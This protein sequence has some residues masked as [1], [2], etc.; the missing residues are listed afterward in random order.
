MN[1]HVTL[2]GIVSIAALYGCGASC[3]N[4]CG[5]GYSDGERAGVVTKFS[6][7][8]L[9]IKSWEGEMALGGITTDVEGNAVANV[10]RFSVRDESLIEKLRTAQ[11]SGK[12][13]T[14]RYTQWFMGPIAVDTGYLVTGV[15]Q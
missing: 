4:G 10:W 1:K 15:S 9:L 6:R 12:R 8:G 11:S 7:K 3:Y 14:L 13:T 2:I 5:E